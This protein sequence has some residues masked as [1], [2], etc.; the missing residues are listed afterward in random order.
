MPV[1]PTTGLHP[2]GA[3][4]APA[5]EEE[6][7][8]FVRECA[9]R[10]QPLHCEGSG[11]KR[12]HGPAAAEGAR[13][14]S[15]RRLS[16]VTAHDPAD[17]VVSVLAGTRL[18]DLQRALAEHKQWLPLDPPYANATIGGVMATASA[19]PRRYGYGTIK[20]QLLG[21]RAVNASGTI[22]RSGGRVVKNVTG[23][24]LHR[25]Q[26]GAMGTLGVI[27]EVHLKVTALPA[28]MAALVLAQASLGEALARLLEVR[29]L[30]LRP[31]AL[32]A[33]DRG[34]AEA[35]RASLPELPGGGSGALAGALA[36]IGFEG[37]EASFERH[38]RDLEAFQQRA[39]ESAL[40]EGGAAER[41]WQ[42]FRDGPARAADQVTVRVGAR[43]HDLPGLLERLDPAAA[44]TTGITCHA[45]TGIA[46]LRLPR[47]PGL[48]DLTARLA[49]WAARAAA[50]QGYALVESAPLGIAGR[51]SL[52]WGTVG[53]SLGRS[54]KD[55]WDP[56]AILNP[57]RLAL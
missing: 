35:L 19:G 15:M 43:P 52:P 33:L 14:L 3:S 7:A 1:T 44:G 32:E 49:D 53:H 30:P 48:G 45:G 20:D 39:A 38:Q 13:R 23:F 28:R 25:L 54:I 29:A 24:D 2:A 22:T 12:H 21:L 31:V 51:E 27:L 6:L 46:R 50:V 4:V 47:S 26:V 5:T 40:L 16:R 55:A 42:A 57:G 36:I 34:A 56:T 18:V 41:L 11:T 17:M 10:K 37:S 9:E 8:A